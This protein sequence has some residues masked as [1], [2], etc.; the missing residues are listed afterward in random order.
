MSLHKLKKLV[1]RS[2]EL[3]CSPKKSTKKKNSKCSSSL[4]WIRMPLTLHQKKVVA[5]CRL[6]SL[7]RPSWC[8]VS[9]TKSATNDKTKFMTT[10]GSRQIILFHSTHRREWVNRALPVRN[11]DHN[12]EGQ[13]RPSQ[14]ES[15]NGVSQ[16]KRL[17][18]RQNPFLKVADPQVES[19]IVLRKP[20]EW[21]LTVAS[22]TR[23]L[24]PPSSICQIRQQSSQ[25]K[26]HL[27]KRW[28]ATFRLQLL[29]EIFLISTAEKTH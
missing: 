8:K 29:A 7:G 22:N 23:I 28:A 24:R 17:N 27:A 21:R 18:S 13:N 6:W 20:R 19:R 11:P 12:P 4:L 10:L 14:A 2:T 1:N 3:Q 9:R 16:V 26:S 25:I 5:L 15:V